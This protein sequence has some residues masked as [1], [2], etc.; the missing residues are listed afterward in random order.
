MPLEG[1][2]CKQFVQIVSW[3][4]IG[5]FLHIWNMVSPSGGHLYFHVKKT[6]WSYIYVKI[7]TLLF[8]SIYSQCSP[9]LFYC[10]TWH[11]TMCLDNCMLYLFW[12]ARVTTACNQL[13][14]AAPIIRGTSSQEANASQ[15]ELDSFSI[16]TLSSTMRVSNHTRPFDSIISLQA[17]IFGIPIYLWMAYTFVVVFSF[18]L[19]LLSQTG[20]YNYAKWLWSA[21]PTIPN[22]YYC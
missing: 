3:V 2:K 6:S 13:L 8:L 18:T 11:T 16:F 4:F 20:H 22:L 21:A 5:R 10:A 1:K 17:E 12:A 14:A 19:W 7:V 15:L 9:R